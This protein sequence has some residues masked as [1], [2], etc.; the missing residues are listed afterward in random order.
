V[1][2][3]IRRRKE[4]NRLPAP[5]LGPAEIADAP[6]QSKRR[7]DNPLVDDLTADLMRSIASAID[8]WGHRHNLQNLP[9]DIVFEQALMALNEMYRHTRRSQGK[10]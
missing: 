6:P 7:A 5:T 10:E 1:L 2:E 8:Q 3:S 4:L 9:Q